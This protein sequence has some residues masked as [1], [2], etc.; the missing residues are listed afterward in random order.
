MGLLHEDDVKHRARMATEKVGLSPRE[1]LRR[2]TNSRLDRYDVF[3]SQ[4]IKDEEL[5]LGV[6]AML[7]EDIGLRVFCDWIEN[8]R[9]DHAATT[10]ADAD[11]IRRAMAVS[12]AL[13][14][15]DS[16]SADVSTWM[17]WEIGWFHGAKRRVCVLPIVRNEEDPYRGREFLGLYPAVEDDDRFVLRVPVPRAKLAARLVPGMPLGLATWMPFEYWATAEMLPDIYLA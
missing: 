3:L 5:V 1:L 17:S 11:H 8:S 2:Q 16:E 7:T 10:S 6:Y 13:M 4:A 14:Y 12:T 9:S 15:I